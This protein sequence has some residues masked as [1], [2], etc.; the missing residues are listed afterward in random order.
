MSAC[1]PQ[2]LA[3]SS[4]F[5]GQAMRYHVLQVIFSAS[6]RSHPHGRSWWSVLL[7]LV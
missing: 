7:L 6:R 3:L 1:G 5:V 2:I 4:N